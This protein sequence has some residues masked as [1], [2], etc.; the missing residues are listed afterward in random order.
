MGSR[1]QSIGKNDLARRDAWVKDHRLS[2]VDRRD[3]IAEIGRSVGRHIVGAQ[4][5]RDSC[6]F[7]FKVQSRAIL[8]GR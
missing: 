6:S 8:A 3:Q 7:E 1:F 5:D 2:A 4:P